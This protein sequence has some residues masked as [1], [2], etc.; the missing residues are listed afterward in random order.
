MTAAI[1]VADERSKVVVN[2]LREQGPVRVCLADLQLHHSDTYEH[3]LRVALLS[4]DLGYENGLEG[5]DLR[6]LGLAGLL[7][8]MGKREIDEAILTGTSPLSEDERS[9]MDEH[10]RR[11]ARLLEEDLYT[12][13]RQI[14]VGHHEYHT[15]A[16]PRQGSDRRAVDRVVDNDRREKDE[17]IEMLTQIV[18]VADMCD[19]LASTRSYK[20]SFAKT[21]IGAAL[22]EQYTGDPVYVGQVLRR[23]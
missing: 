14:V 13:V 20:E 11:G 22:Y 8:D 10:P 9:A 3:S 7:H 1:H 15:S 5:A 23:V 4:V 17:T 19:A 16:F 21:E 18:A 12:K 6:T 2:Q